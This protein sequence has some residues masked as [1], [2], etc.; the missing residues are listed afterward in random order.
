MD[1]NRILNEPTFDPPSSDA[2][3]EEK[4]AYLRESFYEL[5]GSD[6]DQDHIDGKYVWLRNDDGEADFDWP[7][8]L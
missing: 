5:C 6:R 8:E 1:E 2:S 3:L 7:R 4:R